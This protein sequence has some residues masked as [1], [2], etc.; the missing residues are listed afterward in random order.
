MIPHEKDFWDGGVI[1][2]RLT[3]TR[4]SCSSWSLESGFEAVGLADLRA[5]LAIIYHAKS[6]EVEVELFRLL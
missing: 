2:G 3:S 4:C 5:F 6:H 1:G